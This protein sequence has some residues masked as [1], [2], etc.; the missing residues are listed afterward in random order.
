MSH[1]DLV[2]AAAAAAEQSRPPL[3]GII[4][5]IHPKTVFPKFWSAVM[6]TSILDFFLADSVHPYM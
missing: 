2:S 3:V 1:L 6:D 4:T 5:S